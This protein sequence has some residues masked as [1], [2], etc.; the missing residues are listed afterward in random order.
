[1]SVLATFLV[2]A[3]ELDGGLVALADRRITLGADVCHPALQSVGSIA[4]DGAAVTLEAQALPDWARDSWWINREAMLIE[5]AAAD[6]SIC[7]GTVRFDGI[8]GAQPDDEAGIWSL[9]LVPPRRRVRPVPDYGLITAT[10]WPLAASSAMGQSRPLI[11]GEVDVCPLLA[12]RLPAAT[13]L[14]ADAL[15]GEGQLDVEDAANLAESGTVM[16]DG[17]AYAYDAKSS[18][19]NTL[20]GVTV[21]GSHRQGTAVVT[22]GDT[23][24]LAAG[25]ACAAMDD[26]RAAG[27]P[28]TGGTADLAAATVTFAA[29]PLV[30]ERS[31]RFSL[32]AQFDQVGSGTTAQ[33]A[34]N[35]IRAVTGT[36][37]QT[38]TILPSGVTAATANAGIQFARPAGRIVLGAY[39]V[40]FSVAIGSQIGWARVRIGQEVVWMMEPPA[41]VV[42][43]WS[44]ATIT[45]DDDSDIIPVVVEVADGGSDNQVAVTITSA[46]RT[47]S[48]GNLDDANFAT[49][50]GPSNLLWRADQTDALPERGPIAKARLWVRWFANGTTDLPNAAVSFAGR[51]LG[52]LAQTQLSNAT[53]SQTISVDVTSQGAASLPQQNISTVI[54]GGTAS[55]SHQVQAMQAASTNPFRYL[56]DRSAAAYTS[57]MYLGECIVLAPKMLGWLA[58]ASGAIT[59]TIDVQVNYLPPGLPA[60]TNHNCEIQLLTAAYGVIASRNTLAS[61]AAFA[62]VAG[63]TYRHTFTITDAPA[64]IAFGGNRYDYVTPLSVGFAWNGYVTSGA[65]SQDNTPASGGSDPIPAQSLGHSGTSVSTSNGAIN[66]TVPAPPRVVDQF[67]DLSWVRGWPDLTAQAEV[68]YTS[69]GP[70]LCLVQVALVVDYDA[71]V[72]A[73]AESLTARVSGVSGNPA[74]VISLLAAASGQTCDAPALARLAAWAD[75]AGYRYARRLA[76]PT[77]ALTLL[78]YALDQANAIGADRGGSLAPVRRLDV[79]TDITRITESELLEPAA[80]GWAERT[81][82]NIT[83]RYAEDYATGSGFARVVQATADN[84]LYCR[85]SVAAIKETRAITIEA[86]FVRGDATAARLAD[87]LAQWAALPRRVLR[88]ACTY[89]QTALAG[90][91]IEFIPQ[92]ADSSAGILARVT[93]ITTDTGWPTLTAEEI[94]TP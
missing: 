14:A 4:P 43:S 5:C 85:R 32:I 75:A 16:V 84:H 57:L 82:N 46:T 11:V 73:R 65:V 42:Y 20:L 66:F 24:F 27:A 36:V 10:D 17:I 62:V 71:R 21:T 15:P 76:D 86:G 37:E 47:V 59:V 13:R 3:V 64:Y 29:P 91:L 93:S 70:D 18:E 74:D 1:M 31:E 30:V 58:G 94:P 87:D 34:I 41:D 78:Q 53:L 51:A 38:A 12:V 69:G 56:S 61:G 90:D 23:V 48:L 79:A 44:P 77:D 54:S 22:S 2:L 19:G 92:G 9:A 60:L 49:L 55:L 39:T 8:I 7:D 26:L 63:N 25:H 6:Q 28:I 80:I 45:F 81:D 68:A 88:L 35:A 72:L 52:S 33:N 50:K 83:V 40:A 89:A 67:F